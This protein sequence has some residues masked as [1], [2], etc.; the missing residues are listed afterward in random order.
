MQRERIETLLRIID[1]GEFSKLGSVLHS[2]ICYFRPGYAPLQGID[3][4]LSFYRDE[5]VIASGVHHIETIIVDHAAAAC[6]GRFVGRS[7]DGRE[8]DEEFA[9]VYRFAGDQIIHRQTYFFRPA[10]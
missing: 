6:R 7:R 2:D 1:S 3:R 9:D 8:L 10:I 5:R 4:V